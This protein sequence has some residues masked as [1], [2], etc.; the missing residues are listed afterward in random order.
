MYRLANFSI[1]LF[2]TSLFSYVPPMPFKVEVNIENSFGF[3]QPIELSV[4][5]Y[6][7]PSAVNIETIYP[8]IEFEVFIPPALEI[9]SGDLR[10]NVNLSL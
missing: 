10:G 4:V 9:I 3:G 5:A 8:E 6:L 7:N 1:L 2:A